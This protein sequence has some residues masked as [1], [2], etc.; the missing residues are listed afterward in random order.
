MTTRFD[1]LKDTAELRKMLESADWEFEF[2]TWGD[3][4]YSVEIDGEEFYKVVYEDGSV[5]IT[6]DLAVALGEVED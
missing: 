6:D 4:N 3:M 1:L 2:E 5:I